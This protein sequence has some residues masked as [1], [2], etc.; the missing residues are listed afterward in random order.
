GHEVVIGGWTTTGTS[1]R[2]LLVGVNRDGHLVYIGRVGTGF[3]QA[4]VT[5]LLARPRRLQ[6]DKS[7]FSGAAAPRKKPNVHW[8]KPELVAEIEF[9]GWTT[10]GM[11]RQAAF[12]GLREDKPAAEIEAESPAK[13]SRVVLPRPGGSGKK[14]GRT[15][16]GGNAAPAET[17]RGDTA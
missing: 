11:I 10:D 3:G 6:T 14:A 16:N 12:K 13:P 7:P 8:I 5:P 9:A 1:F 4:K 2:S 15:T 17:G